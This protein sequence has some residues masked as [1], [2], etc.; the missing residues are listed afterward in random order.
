[1]AEQLAPG[2]KA[3]DFSATAVGVG[4]GAGETLK[5]S[6]FKGRTVVLYFYPKDD[7]PGC[8]AQACALRPYRSPCRRYDFGK[9]IPALGALLAAGHALAHR[10]PRVV[11]AEDPA[12]VEAIC[13]A[14][15]LPA[16]R[17]KEI[18]AR[19]PVDLAAHCQVR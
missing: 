4:Y 7:T 18:P 11:S 5:L 9:R 19:A 17:K 1:M 12:C 13:A 10:V 3:P 8:T 15:P 2:A 14:L 16:L 6:D